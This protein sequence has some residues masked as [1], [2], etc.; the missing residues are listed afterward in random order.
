MVDAQVEV[1]SLVTDGNLL[2]RAFPKGVPPREREL[3]DR[4]TVGQR[5]RSSRRLDA[6]I[7]W[8]GGHGELTADAAA[9]AAG[10]SLSRFYR[11]AAE[12]RHASSLSVLGAFA[13]PL[14]R[15]S[16]FDGDVINAL[17]AKVGSVVSQNG[18]V[19]VT[20][21]VDLL[22]AS[23]NVPHGKLPGSTKLR[24]IVQAELRRVEATHDAGTA[25]VIDVVAVSMARSD[26]RPHVMFV[27]IDV[28]TRAILGIS[29]GDVSESVSGH[30]AAAADALVM[31]AGN[32][33]RLPWGRRLARAE[34]TAGLDVDACRDLVDRLKR[35]ASGANVQL[36]TRSSRF[37]RYVRR[38]VGP[39]F[40]RVSI[41]PTRTV[42][43]DAMVQDATPWSEIDAL[44][45]LRVAA[46]S[47]NATL[48]S[49]SM[50]TGEATEAPQSLLQ[51]LRELAG[52]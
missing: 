25:I 1:C 27:C 50:D 24:E 42:A 20:S 52:A 22:I 17:Q 8:N 12:W 31:I 9:K 46:A 34:L 44:A 23:I 3:W 14:S 11:L 38:L 35:D 15:R 21:L 5:E 33:L 28:G 51:M 18:G 39:R 19:S 41:T 36:S 48:T 7:D 6:I 30:S 47:H 13:L 32:A 43:G 45:E 49:P 16:K 37:G 4:L 40:G 26:G 2:A 10:L 29:L